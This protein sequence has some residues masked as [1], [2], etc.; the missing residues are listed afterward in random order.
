LT[1]ANTTSAKA[2]LILGILVQ[3]MGGPKTDGA[4]RAA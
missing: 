3:I 2:G 4:V 1:G